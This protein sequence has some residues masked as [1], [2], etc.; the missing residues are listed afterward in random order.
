MKTIAIQ[1]QEG[2]FHQVAAQKL[3]PGKNRLLFCETF[4]EVFEHVF[5]GT[6]DYG[7]VATQNTLHGQI[8]ETA[9]LF[10][11]YNPKQLESL[12]LQIRHCLIGLRDAKLKEISEIYSQHMAFSQCQLYLNRELPAAKQIN[13]HDTA[14]AVAY[15]A[16]SRDPHKAAIASEAAAKVHD[17][18]ILAADIQDV[19][20]NQTQFVLFQK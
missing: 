2:S 4:D 3:V 8:T 17:L 5:N 14:A 19:S 18:Q 20:H 12:W 16:K 6:A 15:V 9:K 13:Y 1:G 10:E 7:V 11:Q